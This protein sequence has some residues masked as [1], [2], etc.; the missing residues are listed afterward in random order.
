ME[1]MHCHK[2]IRRI[3]MIN[4]PEIAFRTY[5][6]L[7]NDFNFSRVTKSIVKRLKK[8]RNPVKRAR[9]VF[10]ELDFELKELFKDKTIQKLV[11]CKSGCEAC[12]HTQVSVTQYES[13]LLARKV[14][15]GTTIDL[16]KLAIQSKA[17]NLAEDW[18]KLD[19]ATRGCLFLDK[20]GRCTVYDD[21]PGV[22]RTNF[23]ISNPDNCKTDQGGTQ[24]VRL[25]I[26]HKADMVLMGA[27][28]SSKENGALPF[29]L[30]KSLDRL[31]EEDKNKKPA[32][33]EE[34]V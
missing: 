20:E 10:R 25:L 21:R 7:K 11:S 28:Q 23:V 5:E 33:S 22:C 6:K 32:P 2:I 31:L 17:K 12:C 8:H 19:Y 16:D 1:G 14:I 15:A 26:T 13:D 3:L 24:P 18:Y 29:M 34:T 4:F 30:Y 27:F 9:L